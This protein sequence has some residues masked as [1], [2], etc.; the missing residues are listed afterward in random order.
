LSLR[1][2]GGP[3][4]GPSLHGDKEGAAPLFE[5]LLHFQLLL[6]MAGGA[7]VCACG[8]KGKGAEFIAQ[9]EGQI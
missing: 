9:E 3:Q 6:L 7:Q 1:L 5:K 2:H 8:G 4:R